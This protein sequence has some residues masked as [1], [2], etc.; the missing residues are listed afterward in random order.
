VT[1]PRPDVS[2]ASADWTPGNA[3]RQLVVTAATLIGVYLAVF[4]PGVL[5]SI[6]TALGFAPPHSPVA[7]PDRVAALEWDVFTTGVVAIVVLRWLPR[8]A[9]LVTGR[10]RS[11]ARLAR[12]IPGGLLG[13]AAVYVAVAAASSR[14]GDLVVSTWHLPHGRYTQIGSGA[15]SFFV[16]SAA[17]A[18]AGFTEEITLVALA[19]AV[20][21]QAFSAERCAARWRVPTRITVLIGLRLFVH[22]YYL[23]GSVFVLAW[24]PG[25]Y[26]LY[27]WAGSVWPLV[28]GH[29]CYDW[30]VVAQ[31]TFPRSARGFGAAVDTVAAVGV[32]VVVVALGRRIVGRPAVSAV[33]GAGSG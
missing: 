23:W 1:L 21:E 2:Q 27:R 29:W 4:G 31:Q 5:T 15:G 13:A 3:R 6:R 18:A 30:L 14:A 7:W 32:A 11:C 33:G 26:L 12:P 16:T 22:L 28:I 10:M 8:H 24:V 20:V 9:P 19:A 17:A 25:V